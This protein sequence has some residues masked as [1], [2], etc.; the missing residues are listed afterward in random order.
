MSTFGVNIDCS[1]H[2]HAL[3]TVTN[4]TCYWDT[5]EEEPAP[6]ARIGWISTPTISTPAPPLAPAEPLALAVTKTTADPD[7][8]I[9]SIPEEDTSSAQ[10]AKFQD[11]VSELVSGLST[12]KSVAAFELWANSIP[13]LSMDRKKK[14]MSAITYFEGDAANWATPISEIINRSSI[15]GSGVA[16][17]YNTWEE[18]VTAV[19]K[20]S[21]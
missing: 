14:I 9:Q 1:N 19:T 2:F 6:P 5:E 16:F 8:K 18:F 12:T 13:A 11:V 20:R 4:T 7:I 15:I 3:D 10:D 17:P 21:D